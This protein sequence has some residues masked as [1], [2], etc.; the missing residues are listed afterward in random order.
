MEHY[1]TGKE[2]RQYIY[3]EDVIKASIASLIINTINKKLF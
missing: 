1:G 2:I 3:I